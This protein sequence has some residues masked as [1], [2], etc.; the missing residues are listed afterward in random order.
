[1]EVINIERILDPG[2]KKLIKNILESDGIIVYPTDTLYGIGGNFFS[3]KVIKK[4]D[5]LKQREDIP[6]SAAAAGR[7]MINKLAA[8]LPPYFDELE[9]EIF[10]GKF[11]VLLKVSKAIDRA[12]VKNRDKIGIRV[13]AVP[14]L[15]KL[16]E[17]LDF[18]LISTSVNRSGFPPLRHPE[19][20]KREFP[21]IDLLIDAGELPGSKGSTVLDLLESS[22]KVVRVGDDFDK[23]KNY[24]ENF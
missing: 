22:I 23:I 3:L 2:S 20:I 8:E 13:P 18:P 6:Y 5:R 24:L 1:M 15:L 17:Y 21:G 16:I 7:R 4:I 14:R 10:P 12:L 19:E 11:T 9:E